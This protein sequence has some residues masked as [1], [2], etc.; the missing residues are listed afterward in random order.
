[1]QR[2]SSPDPRRRPRGRDRGASLIEI[3]IA[4]SLL[5]LVVGGV[6]AAVRTSISASSVAYEGGQLETLLLN[7][8]DKVQRAPQQ[9]EGYEE[10][11]DAAALAQG[12]D[13]ALV[14]SSVELLVANTGD[15]SAD[16]TPQPCPAD[17]G[18]FDV[19]RVEI[20]ATTP[21]GDLTRHL[22][23]VKSSVD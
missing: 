17:V 13:P 19:Q 2:P 5:A 20:S 21:N 3:V 23:V 22:T 7:A 12:W 18:P 9:C 14:S 4:I 11:V 1:M 8:A 15:P 10:Y 6:L 16:W